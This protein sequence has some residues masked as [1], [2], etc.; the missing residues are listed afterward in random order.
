M[1]TSPLQGGKNTNVY[2]SVMLSPLQ[3]S[4]QFMRDHLI[5][6]TDK[7][8]YEFIARHVDLNAKETYIIST[9]TRF[10]IT[11]NAS[12]GSK[13]IVNLARVN[14]IR[15]INKFFESVN[16]KLDQGGCF[17]GCAE[18]KDLR[19]QRIL[20]KFPWGIN[21]LMYTLDF[22]VKR[23]F[24][25]FALTKRLYFFLTRGNNRVLT[26]AE[27]LGR[28]YSC[29]FEVQDE[30]FLKGRL[31]F[32]ATKSKRP[33]YDLNPTYGPLVRLKRLGKNGKII[34]VYKFRTMH[35][36]A[37]YLQE[38]IY[39]QNNLK[40]GGKFND[41]FRVSTLGKFMRAFWIDELPMI[42]NVLKGQMKLV[43]VRPISAHYYSLYPAELQEKRIMYK[44]GL[45]PP[46]Y[47]DMPKTLDEIVESELRYLSLFE[48]KPLL[49]Q[50]RYFWKAVINILIHRARSS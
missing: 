45:I 37:E 41:D 47:A 27:I 1:S 38:Y 18:T 23:I 24:P 6:E 46:Y 34:K 4:W 26:R 2:K 40:E 42:I 28:L 22:T 16:A 35:P 32:V 36:F 7:E 9:T 44:P 21:Y 13:A 33:S 25:K 30:R 12:N 49:T 5:E 29:G 8:A 15:Y 17:V 19:K 11:Y 43:G 48:Q 14:D 39:Q 3:V 50:W 20:N 10:N 31:Y